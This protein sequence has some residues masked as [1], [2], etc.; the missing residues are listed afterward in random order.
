MK[1]MIRDESKAVLK[2]G[3][4]RSMN[5]G[6]YLL[7]ACVVLLL[8]CV[9]LLI[10]ESK[11]ELLEIE[12]LTFAS[13]GSRELQLDLF[14]PKE[15]SEALPAII[16]IHGGGW[17]GGTR[18]SGHEMARYFAERNYVA[19]AISYRLSGEAPF[20]AQI[21]DCKAAVRW[22]RANAET[23][24]I[25]PERIGA[26]G[27]S[28]G[29]HLAALLATSAG[30]EELEGDGGNEAFSSALQA[31]VGS[32][33]QTDFE[34]DRIRSMTAQPEVLAWHAF[35]G[36]S[37]DDNE[38]RYQLAS[39]RRHLD[40]DDPPLMIITGELDN[41]DTRADPIRSD[42]QRMNI[43]T[44]LLVIPENT[45]GYFKEERSAELVLSNAAYFFDSYLKES[46]LLTINTARTLKHSKKASGPTTQKES[47]E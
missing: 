35:L 27:N 38:E 24:G 46:D 36:G 28:A 47:N 39:P 14:K 21:H 26:I 11:A 10:P 3:M 23:Y 22:L 4:I 19:V 42:M 31:A 18:D 9:V 1:K 45:H 37:L 12:G 33:A 32:G 34:T 25:D 16:W 8:A 44:G 29:G 13:Y 2:K 15:Q 41:L 6:H 30:V 40:R 20:P 7:L 17:R 43:P 5:V